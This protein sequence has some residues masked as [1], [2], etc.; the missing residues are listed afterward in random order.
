[1][2]N[3]KTFRERYRPPWHVEESDSCFTVKTGSGDRLATVYYRDL[4]S[5]WRIGQFY[6]LNRAEAHAL[7]REIAKLGEK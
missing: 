5:E 7:A 2:S 1:M 6:C 3:L 4:P